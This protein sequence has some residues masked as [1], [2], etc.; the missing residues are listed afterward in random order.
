MSDEAVARAQAG[1]RSRHRGSRPPSGHYNKIDGNDGRRPTQVALQRT[2]GGAAEARNL[3]CGLLM[4]HAAGVV[5]APKTAQ[6]R[7]ATHRARQGCA[8]HQRTQGKNLMP[9]KARASLPDADI[10]AGWITCQPGEVMCDW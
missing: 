10:K 7:E 6:A 4:C 2:G 5:G 1:R 3:R 8:V 9:P